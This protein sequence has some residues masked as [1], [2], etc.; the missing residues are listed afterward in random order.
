V[1]DRLKT[2]GD[3]RLGKPSP[4][5]PRLVNEDLERVVRRAP[6]AKPKRALEHVGLKDR[7]NHRLHGRLNNAIADRRDRERTPL[8]RPAGLRDE[9][10]AGGKR[11]PTPCLQIRGQLVKQPGNPVPL[12]VGDGLSVDAGRAV[13][14][15]HQL[16]R[17]LQNV[18]AVDLVI[19]R[20]KPSSGIGLGRP[21]KR[22]LQFSDLIL[23]GGPSHMA[24]TDP[25]V[26]VTHERSS[27]P[28]LTAGSVVPSAQAVLRPPPTPTRP[29]IHFPAHHQL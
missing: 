15:A 13:V 6:G 1:R 22:S 25:S 21:V 8:L 29:A 3:I 18:S 23:L 14:G 11:T 17:T 5:S 2:V 4:A 9:H 10:P 20:V 27:G 12:D 7:L 19:E 26:H 16:P 28:S 24:L